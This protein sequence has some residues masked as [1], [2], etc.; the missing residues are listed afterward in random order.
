MRICQVTHAYYPDLVG[1][2]FGAHDF[3]KRILASGNEC[4][5]VTWALGRKR[6]TMERIDGV[7]VTRLTGVNLRLL[8]AISEFPVLFGMDEALRELK[9][10]LIQAHSHL[11]PSTLQAIRVARSRN[12][13]IVVTVRWLIAKRGMAAEA[14]QW[15]YIMTVCRRL[16]PKAD[17]VV[18]LTRYERDVLKSLGFRCEIEV[19]PN[20]VDT[21]LFKPVE[22]K[23][24]HLI[25]WVGRMVPEKGL[26][27]LLRA[28]ARL[29]KEVPSLDSCLW[30][31]AR[32]CRTSRIWQ[33]ALNSEA[34]A[35]F[36][37][38]SRPE[39]CGVLSAPLRS[40]SY[41]HSGRGLPKA[42][43]EA[44]SCANAVIATEMPQLPK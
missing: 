15:A 39:M 35:H 16:L 6:P 19:I 14:A 43:L 26:E 41:L 9:P 37:G 38:R 21:N 44:M 12:L 10:D 24:P 4:S 11:F 30:E 31:M 40:S 28:M 17:L 7:E 36:S 42:L 18:C 3:A 32:S 25:T 13:P 1:D 34:R 20:G 5:A 27:V 33:S 29:R 8:P 23:D 2:V 22:P